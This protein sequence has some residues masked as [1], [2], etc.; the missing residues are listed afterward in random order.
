[1]RDISPGA[2]PGIRW[3]EV[4]PTQV[5]AGAPSAVSAAS[6]AMSPYTS[7]RAISPRGSPAAAKS[8]SCVWGAPLVSPLAT[9]LPS[10][11][12][13]RPPIIR[14]V[15]QQVGAAQEPT[16]QSLSLQASRAVTPQAAT[17][18]GAG[19]LKDALR[20]WQTPDAE[21]LE[22]DG[23]KPCPSSSVWLRP[24]DASAEGVS[25]GE[26]SPQSTT[27][28]APPTSVALAPATDASSVA[29][30]W[31][32]STATGV[33]AVVSVAVTGDAS[34]AGF[35]DLAGDAG[36]SP[37]ESP[38]FSAAEAVVLVSVE[39]PARLARDAPATEEEALAPPTPPEPA[40]AP[41]MSATDALAQL[42]DFGGAPKAKTSPRPGAK[43]KAKTAPA[44]PAPLPVVSPD[45]CQIK[46]KESLSKMAD[47]AQKTIKE[48]KHMKTQ[49]ASLQIVLQAI[50]V[51]LDLP[52]KKPDDLKKVLAGPDRAVVERLRAADLDAMTA[53]RNRKLQR[54]LA[55]PEFG[56]DAIRT[57]CSSLAPLASW[58]RAAGVWL[59]KAKFAER[60]AESDCMSE[61]PSAS[62]PFFA[63]GPQPVLEL[64]PASARSTASTP[65]RSK[66]PPAKASPRPQPARP[67]SPRQLAKALEESGL[68][69]TPDVTKLAAKALR[70]VEELSV[71][72][73]GVGGITF[74]GAVD[75]TGLDFSKLVRLDVGS[76]IVYPE[77]GSKPARGE[78]LNRQATVRMEQCWMQN[79]KG[80]QDPEKIRRRIKKMTEEK[81]ADFVDYDLSTGVWTFRVEEF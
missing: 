5:F 54:I 56:E 15:R 28:E 66:T 55:A 39:E 62:E 70:R 9:P 74:H 57:S 68:I 36:E 64:A 35:A 1:M 26:P 21:N 48:L 46:D 51:L 72:K 20:Q 78:G 16:P 67:Q 81:K 47:A 14:K 40:P 25:L 22:G 30:L 34:E 63:E 73:P 71:E 6:C 19:L 50:A 42:M 49:P 31:A 80:K 75:C 12:E 27:T 58:C 38:S 61:A 7:P 24:P 59:Q 8:P 18:R 23:L 52:D 77:Q 10:S 29:E 37:C 33:A 69:V 53:V 43:A 76:V 65:S 79:G 11:D 3:K 32:I 17:P 13:L 4:S 45:S 60:P 2:S 41:R 44:R